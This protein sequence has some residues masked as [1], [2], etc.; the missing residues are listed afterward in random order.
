M[1]AVATSY[2]WDM[3]NQIIQLKMIEEPPEKICIY[4]EYII[5]YMCKIQPHGKSKP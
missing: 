5:C 3:A 4:Y 1:K 2:W